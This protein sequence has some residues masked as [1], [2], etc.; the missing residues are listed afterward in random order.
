MSDLLAKLSAVPSRRHGSAN[1][2]DDE[3]DRQLRDLIAY[4]KQPGL[5]PG[6]ANINEYFE[7][8]S[9]SVH[10]LSFLYL[11][12]FQIQQAQKRSKRDIPDDLLPG[13][14]LWKQTVSFLR[15]FDPIQIRY[16]GLEWRQLVELVASA[17]QATLKPVLALKVI[18]DALERLDSSGIFTS[19]HLLLVKLALLT[20]S[21]TYALPI[22]DKL[23]SHFPTDTEHAHSERFLCS[24]HDSSL[25]F[26]TDASGF[27]SKLTYRDHLLFFLYSAMIYMAL[28][29]WDQ[30][31][32]CLCAVISSPTTNSI[33][34][35]MVEA[36]KKLILAN[37]LGHGKLL[38]TPK[39]VA[40]HVTRV[41]QSLARPYISLA[42]AF[43]GGDLQKMS[44]EIDLGQ[45]IWRADNNTGLISQ[46]PEA[47]DKF[48]IIKLG[49]TFS[50]VTMRDVLQ[51]VSSCTKEPLDIEEF[52]SSLVMSKELRATLSQSSSSESLTMLRFSLRTQSSVFQEEHI[53]ARLVRGRSALNAIAGGIAQTDH[54]LELSQENLQF[55]AKN[56]RW[57]ANSEKPGTVDSNEGGGG[58]DIDE[59]LMGEGN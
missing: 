58:G 46:L 3:Y 22:V 11:L 55:L 57:S 50:A 59:D 56:Q 34:K 21:Y 47:H 28:K 38:P 44:A 10:S 17:A 1:M 32:H 45:S 12:R 20:S 48:M 14:I 31:S 35:I 52:V 27:S 18:R 40:P 36:Y 24:E 42:E 16:A 5:V 29:K 54:A 25:A 8:I 23:F 30:A 51:R 39:L 4:L 19:V 7:A 2:T 26:L 43:E 6:G 9:P 37:L 13:G 49:K 53:R 15:S 41:Y 33:S